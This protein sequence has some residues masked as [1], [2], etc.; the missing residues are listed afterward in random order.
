MGNFMWRPARILSLLVL[1]SV[2]AVCAV[3][4]T[5][6]DLE[7]AWRPAKALPSTP[8]LLALGKTTYESKCSACHGSDGRGNGE[9]AYLLYPKPRDFVA[10][11]Y[12][13]VSTWERIPTDE[14]LFISISRGMPGSAMPSWSHLTEEV[15]W[16][17][18]HYIKAF[19][20][21]EL[22]VPP[23]APPMNPGELGSGV[24]IVPPVPAYTPDAQKR[25]A[26]LFSEGCAGCHGVQGRG[27][28]AQKQIDEE[29]IA[30]RPRDLTRGIYK[31]SPSPEAVFRRIVAG[32]PGTPMPMSDWAYG[33]D[34]WHLVN[35]VREMS[36]DFQRAKNEMRMFEIAATRVK[37]LPDH[38]DA[39]EWRL[40]T[41]INL[42]L[43]PLWWRDDRTEE[44]TVRAVHD[45]KDLAVLM[46]WSDLTH[47]Q[48]AMRPQDF[49]DAAAVQFALTPDPPFFGMGGKGQFVNLWMWKSERQADLEPAYQDLDKVYPNIG[50]DS[51]PNFLK[52]PLE[53][54][55]RHALTLESDPTY[56]TGWG[57]GNIVSDPTWKRA[58][59][60]LKAQGFG[61]LQAR[62]LVDQTVVADGVYANNAYSVLFRRA[63]RP[64]GA[65]VVRLVP[66]GTFPVAFAV[67]DGS[68]GDRDGEKS[69]TIWQDL[70]L[71]P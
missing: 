31:G 10:A 34:G 37:Q 48:T 66:G 52:T 45:G 1:S 30:T 63:L 21:K 5:N 7:A 9:A 57:A 15:R 39:G 50:I 49:R 41:P 26:Q 62:P 3:S 4:E 55:E 18:V 11:R 54:P 23:S 51:Y 42:H 16:G 60:D 29:G 61:T 12:R 36:S 65:D 22:T 68:A 56:V 32:I 69:I 67:W 59:E 64:K 35:F 20:E 47:N 14:D 38:P 2:L 33:D 53:Q 27:D 6:H 19:A 43:M 8:E 13:L 25:A 24:M 17:L 58:A 40:A 70:K 71:A 46:V 28:G 44:V